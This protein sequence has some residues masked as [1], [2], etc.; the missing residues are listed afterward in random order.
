[1]REQREG[2]GSRGGRAIW[3]ALAAVLVAL[4]ACAHRTPPPTEPS[5][6]S[7]EIR[8][9]LAADRASL[10]YYDARARLEEMGPEVD[11][12][13][14]SL[15]R[16]TRSR[17]VPRSN[18]LILLAERGSPAAISVLGQVLLGEEIEMLRSAAVIGLQR[19]ATHSDSAASLVRSAVGD[20]ARTVRLNAL[21]ALD[22]R[23]VETIR[24]LLETET[25]S[26]VRTV[27]VQLVALAESRGAP[28]ALDRRGALRTTGMESDPQIVFRA[29]ASGSPAGIAVGDLRVELPNAADVPLAAA[30]EVVGGVVPAFFSADRS[31]VV[32]EVD[33]EIRVIDL[34]TRE[35]RS[36]GA[37]ITP[38]IVPFSQQF[39]FLREVPDARRELDG[40]TELHYEVFR[41]TFSNGEPEL[42][43]TTSALAR[44]H[45][46]ANYSAVRWMVVGETR[47]GFALRGHGVADFPLPPAS[48]RPLQRRAPDGDAVPQ[49]AGSGGMR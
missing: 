4:P 21:Q 2:R 39:V 30:A 38:R 43:G 45:T 41:A 26:E 14:V 28:L 35:I 49:P 37:G 42:I 20:P 40:G 9:L 48:S 46:Y 3:L 5:P 23:E 6:F 10:E 15:A 24:R 22:I 47:D 11:A 29:R 25:D 34:G 7:H 36:L 1:M 31:R 16:D 19:L 33:R 44:M 18:A 32:Y 8:R 13:L 27:A 17:P 12:V